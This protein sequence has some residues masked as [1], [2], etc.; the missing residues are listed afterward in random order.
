MEKPVK[1]C[2]TMRDWGKKN[3]NMIIHKTLYLISQDQFLGIIN[4][5]KCSRLVQAGPLILL[6]PKIYVST[7]SFDLYHFII[8][9]IWHWQRRNEI[10]KTTKLNENLSERC[11]T[12]FSK[13]Y[14]NLQKLLFGF[15]RWRFIVYFPAAGFTKIGFS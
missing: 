14:Y 12:L 8:K 7:N 4:G 1:N 3:R 11:A 5:R 6:A 10:L 2:R 13:L 15:F 9:V